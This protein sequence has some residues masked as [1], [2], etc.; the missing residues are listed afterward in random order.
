MAARKSKAPHSNR[1]RDKKELGLIVATVVMFL[2]LIAGLVY[3]RSDRYLYRHSK[4]SST[5]QQPKKV[6]T[7][8]KP[9]QIQTTEQTTEPSKAQT[10]ATDIVWE[11]QDSSVQLPI[12]MYHA[13]HVMAPG[14]EGNAN[15]IVSPTT[16]ESHLQ[17]LKEAGYYAVSPEEAY[18][19]LT[20]NVLPKGKKVVWLTFDDSLWDFYDIA[21]PLLKQ[22]QMQ[23]TNNVI[24]GTVGQEANL[25]LDEM[26]EM[27]ENGI[28]LQGHTVTHPPLGNTDPALQNTELADSKTFLDTNLSQDTISLAYPSGNYTAETIAIVEKNNYK[29]ALTTNEG[30]ASAANG[31]FSLNRVRVLPYMTAELLLQTIATE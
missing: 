6:L 29:M 25:S 12:L 8:T 31:L 27:K 28:S 22:Y 18:K 17:A 7:E 2:L 19:I 11:K 23:A 14:E 9:T 21:Y 5:V 10:P 26:K 30:I 3:A 4:A 1:K 24:T 15:L 16:F 20:E 13:I